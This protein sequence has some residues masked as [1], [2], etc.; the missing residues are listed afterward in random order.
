MDKNLKTFLLLLGVTLLL[1]PECRGVCS[2]F[3]RTLVK[4]VI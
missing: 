2:R 1:V 4:S 3:A